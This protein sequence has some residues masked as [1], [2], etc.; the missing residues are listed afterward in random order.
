MEQ[1]CRRCGE[2]PPKWHWRASRLDGGHARRFCGH[3][4]RALR[5][6]TQHAA[7][8]IVAAPAPAATV[9]H[10]R[11]LRGTE[12]VPTKATVAAAKARAHRGSLGGAVAKARRHGGGLGA[13]V[14]AAHGGR[15][16]AARVRAGR[17]LRVGVRAFR[18]LWVAACWLGGASSSCSATKG[19]WIAP[20]KGI[21]HV[22]E[23]GSPVAA[24]TL[25]ARNPDT[26]HEDMELPPIEEDIAA[27]WEE[28]M[29]PAPG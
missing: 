7:A 21:E 28:L 2:G 19:I 4:R 10:R 11:R 13:G 9:G 20:F 27:A 8:P 18:L 26:T 12:A 14:A 3:L 5:G 24:R 6:G 16:G 15:H 29:P 17:V 22:T 23:A 1:V 25:S